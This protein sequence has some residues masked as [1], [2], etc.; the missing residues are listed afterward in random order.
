MPF[1]KCYEGLQVRDFVELLGW[2]VCWGYGTAR[3]PQ[4]PEIEQRCQ[5]RSDW[6]FLRKCLLGDCLADDW[7][8]QFRKRRARKGMY[9]L[10]PTFLLSVVAFLAV[11]AGVVV[12]T[13]KIGRPAST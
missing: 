11:L 3:L 6:H 10:I 9:G 1:A 7:I 2:R 12:P 5:E 4:T 8:V 13:V